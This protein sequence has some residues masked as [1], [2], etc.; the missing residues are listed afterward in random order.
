MGSDR[1]LGARP[2][3][4][5]G[6]RHGYLAGWLPG[7]TIVAIPVLG[8][9]RRLRAGSTADW[10]TQTLQTRLV[11]W[12]G[13]GI[14]MLIPRDG[15]HSIWLFTD[16]HRADVTWY[17]NLEQRHRWHAH[18]CDTR[19]ELLDLVCESPRAWRWKDE[20]ELEE[21][22]AHGVLGA[23]DASAVR[24]EGERVARRIERWE[25]PFDDGWD[26]WEADP[27]WPLPVLPPDWATSAGELT[28][29]DA[30]PTSPRHTFG[31]IT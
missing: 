13:R 7:G 14:L 29:P 9:G 5:V 17:V 30:S 28:T 12:E 19:D 22:V 4:F 23:D 18:G 24:A 25:S 15:A 2:L 31:T 1:L 20:D 26:S 10:F 3:R 6:E 21:A 16:D 27:S 8:D 11:P